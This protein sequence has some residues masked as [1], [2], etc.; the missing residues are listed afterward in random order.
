MWREYVLYLECSVSEVSTSLQRPMCPL[1]GGSVVSSCLIHNYLVLFS[2]P[3]FSVAENALNVLLAI[4]RSGDCDSLEGL[5]GDF[6]TLP[7]L[8]DIPA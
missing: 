8:K 2:R 3:N 5:Q 7:P 1:F 4:S 6:Y